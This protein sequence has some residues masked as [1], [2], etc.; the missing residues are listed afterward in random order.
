MDSEEF[1]FIIVGAGSAGCVLANRLSA[2]GGQRVLLLEAGGRDNSINIHIPLMV[3]HLLKDER[4][5]WPFLTEKQTH[6]NDRVQ[7]W[8]RGKVLGGSSSING[9]VYVRGAQAEFDAWE[10]AGCRGW[11]W[12]AML[13][14]FKRMEN[15][16]NG[17]PATLGKGGPINVT[18]LKNFDAL[19]DA[20]LAANREAGFELVEDYFDGHY[21]GAAYLQYS[22]RR[23]FR[24]S[25]AVG[26]LRPAERRP[27]LAV[28]ID[29]V[30]T[31]VLFEGKHAVGV[32]CLRDGVRMTVRARKE[33]IL[34]AGPVQS[35]KLLELSGIGQPALLA[36]H[37]IE[38]VHELEGVG[39]NLADHLNTRLTFECSAPITINDVLQRPLTKIEEGL[40]YALFGK[41]LLSIC[42]AIAHT[43]MHSRPGPHQ[44]DL[45]LQLQPFSGKDRYAR[46][47]QDGLDAFS[48]FTIGVMALR[49]R[50]RGTVHIRSADPLAPPRIDPNHLA[51]EDDLNVLLAGIRAVRRLTATDALR[52][53]VVRETRPG[54]EVQT[55]AEIIEYIRATTQTTWH[56]GG[57]CS[58][59]VD[60]KSVVDPELRVHG[61]TG[62]RVVD[63]SAFP[64]V[65]SSNTNAPTIALGEKGAEL[66][67][68]AWRNFFLPT[69]ARRPHDRT[70]RGFCPRTA[71]AVTAHFLQWQLRHRPA[72][73]TDR[74]TRL[75]K[76]LRRRR[77]RMRADPPDQP[78]PFRRGHHA[79]RGRRNRGNLRSAADR[80]RHF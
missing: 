26:Y 4:Y 38:L 62:L 25:S 60:K 40:R 49:P 72:E 37:G 33:V 39:E 78:G 53:M 19:A 71:G 80:P 63:S 56:V 47:P 66:I 12:Q 43:V 70:H 76:T 29:T 51:E 50:S 64:T 45:K 61:V 35:P 41:G 3:V 6:L 65:R 58:M 54:A 67:E 69:L 32:E 24:S 59:G 2:S 28:W 46:R 22:T 20:Y 57:S 7:L 21:E 15:F 16:S 9:K 11:G 17:A 30:V 23:G 34:S 79:K 1:D 14:Y 5:T 44:P 68:R 31:R 77:G 27:N 36:E 74:Q 55:D 10:A 75:R 42:S 18:E 8:A 73:A 52:A 48:G 13:P